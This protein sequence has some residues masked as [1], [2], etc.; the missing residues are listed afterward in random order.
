VAAKRAW[1]I[2]ATLLSLTAAFVLVSAGAPVTGCYQ[3]DYPCPDA[4]D[5]GG[6]CLTPTGSGQSSTCLIDGTPVTQCAPGSCGPW[7]LSSGQT[8]DIPTGTLWATLGPRIDL[9]WFVDCMPP[10]DSALEASVP[11][12]AT[13]EASLPE[14]SVSEASVADGA[15]SEASAPDASPG[16]ESVGAQSAGTLTV[17]FDG[18]PAQGCVCTP[19][20]EITCARVPSTVQT[21]GFQYVEAPAT[22]DGGLDGGVDAGPDASPDGGVD[23]GPVTSIALSITFDVGEC[24]PTHGGCPH[25]DVPEGSAY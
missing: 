2:G 20:T 12:G 8:L 17:L 11:D 19:Q 7:T 3:C 5:V 13:S 21:I 24:M 23:A 15:T 16:F 10:S 4:F 6:Y 25:S 22:I 14:S 18:V 9:H 1:A